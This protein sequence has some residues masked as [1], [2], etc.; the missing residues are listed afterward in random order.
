LSNKFFVHR[1]GRTGRAGEKGTAYTLV[2]DKDFEFAGHLVRNLEGAGQAVPQDVLDLA[3]KVCR[4]F[5]YFLKHK[6]N[7][8][9]LLSKSSWFRKSRFKQGRGKN[10]ALV[11]ACRGLGFM[12]D[13][14]STYATASS[15]N[16]YPMI[17]KPTASLGAGVPT[18]RMD[19]M[20]AA[21]KQQYMS[22]VKFFNIN[23]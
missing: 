12:D 7:I 23:K 21:F 19:A 3:M 9:S 17:P 22:N 11:G 14:A 18:N 5:L 10:A 6:L 4:W 20:K 13:T 8:T 16:N 1:I 15:T 2:T